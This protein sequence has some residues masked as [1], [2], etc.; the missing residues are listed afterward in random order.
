MKEYLLI[1]DERGTTR[2]PSRTKTWAFGGFIIES[3]DGETLAA[4]WASIK[5]NLCGDPH[6]ELKW[7]HFFPGDH[8]QKSR[9]PLLSNSPEDWRKQAS[10]ALSELF[11]VV[12]MSAV[13]TVVRK[14]EASQSVF[15]R[16]ADGRQVL[17]INIIWVSVVAQFTLFLEQHSGKGEIWFDRLG[18]D[19]EEAR[20]QAEWEQLQNG[21][22]RV[23]VDNQI[24][25]QRIAPILRFLDSKTEP[26]VQIADFISGV[27]WAASEGD[28][29]FLLKTL[30]KYF[31]GGRRTY[32]LVHIQ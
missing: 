3:S 18:S 1:C 30:D 25:I 14:D 27:I 6:N 2:W 29:E 21:D 10:W 12:D 26:L 22:W 7:S 13:N 20:R 31:P 5:L 9:N 16:K 32:A 8:Q 19:K 28:D 23:E 24:R 4:K 11:S 17:D 15:T